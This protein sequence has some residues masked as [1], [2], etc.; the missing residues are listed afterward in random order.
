VLTPRLE[1]VIRVVARS[2]GFAGA[3]YWSVSW[4]SLWQM[5]AKEEAEVRKLLADT[6]T[7]NI[8]S[9]VLLPEEVAVYRGGEGL[10]VGFPTVDVE[11]REKMLAMEMKKVASGETERGG[12]TSSSPRAPSAP[13]APASPSTKSEESSESDHEMEGM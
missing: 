8:T 10:R 11:A 5:T 9:G 4:P 12:A 3:D 13:A 2:E 7:A 6:D 1:R